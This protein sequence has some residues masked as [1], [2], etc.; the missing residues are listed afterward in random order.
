NAFVALYHH[1][2]RPGHLDLMTL[3]Q[4]M[5][6]GAAA[7]GGMP[8][9]SVTSGQRASLVLLDLEVEADLDPGQF[10]SLSRNCPFNGERLFGRVDGLLV[11]ERLLRF[12]D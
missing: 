5:G 10:R 8:V 1:L 3:L 2:V 11:A 6:P 7:A 12:D 9:G 4:R